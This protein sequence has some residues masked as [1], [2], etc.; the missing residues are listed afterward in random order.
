MAIS[1]E[2]GLATAGS[3]R[4]RAAPVH[5]GRACDETS[6]RDLIPVKYTLKFRPAALRGGQTNSPARFAKSPLQ[7][8]RATNVPDRN[9]LRGSVLRARRAV[10]AG[11][12]NDNPTIN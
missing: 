4:S 3:T 7:T 6:A 5:A 1:E 9:Q 10:P 8:L 12:G 2:K 11:I